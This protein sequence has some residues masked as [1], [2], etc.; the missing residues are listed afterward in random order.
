MTKFLLG[1][2]AVLA[3]AIVGQYFY[4][5]GQ[6]DDLGQAIRSAYSQME[7]LRPGEESK[8]SIEDE[9]LT[10]L[11]RYAPDSVYI[12][13]QYVPAEGSVD[14]VIQRDT[15]AMEELNQLYM[16][17]V[18]LRESG[19]V[20]DTVLDSLETELDRLASN[21]Y[22]T[23]V[24]VDNSGFCM[25]PEAGVNVNESGD[26]G[27]SGGARLFFYNRYG[28]GIEGS[29]YKSDQLF[30][31]DSESEFALGGYGDFRIPPI[32]NVSGKL[33][34]GYNFTD[35]DWS[36]NVGLNFYFRR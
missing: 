33:G 5:N 3:L 11:D 26:F 21:V 18:R 20:S 22:I 30:Q 10:Y 13:Q 12:K 6:I 16:E 35:S 23:E 7:K 28:L 8:I 32:E 19:D 29:V 31:E 27:I 2:I 9:V 17:I 36:V 15:V 34:I 1:I 24:N 25:E 14:I 4:F